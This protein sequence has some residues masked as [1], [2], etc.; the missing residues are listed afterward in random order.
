MT[1]TRGGLGRAWGDIWRVALMAGLL[2]AVLAPRHHALALAAVGV[3]AFVW[4]GNFPARHR[5]LARYV[6]GFVVFAALRNLCDDAGFPVQFTYPIVWERALFGELPTIRLQH[7]LLQPGH[8]GPLEVGTLTVYLTYFFVPPTVVVLLWRLWPTRLHRYVT[9]TFVVFA[10]S[11]VV[12]L[13]APTAP[14]WYAA[15]RGYLTGITQIGRAI[16]GQVSPAAYGYGAGL[17]GN[18]VAAMPSVHL[19]VTVLIACALW[20]TWLRWPALAYILIMA[21]TIVYGAEHYV[22]DCLAGIALALAAWR[23]ARPAPEQV[24]VENAVPARSLAT[25]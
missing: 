23:W 13:L 15:E 5:E 14:P 7:A 9:A 8:F 19:A 18:A 11:G 16:F 21:F 25:S 20:P 10:V 6:A 3:A 17:S 1:V 4:A 22:V 2:F 24:P 12:H